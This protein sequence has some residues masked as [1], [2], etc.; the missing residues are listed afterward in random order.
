MT[1][2]KNIAPGGKAEKT[3][4]HLSPLSNVHDLLVVR[5]KMLTTFPAHKACAMLPLA[6]SHPRRFCRGGDDSDAIGN[7]KLMLMV[8]SNLLIFFIG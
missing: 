4:Q 2:E 7:L 8:T 1:F 3:Q 5:G 6:A